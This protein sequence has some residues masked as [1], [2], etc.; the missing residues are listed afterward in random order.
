[1]ASTMFKYSPPIFKILFAILYGKIQSITNFAESGLKNE[2]AIKLLS[3]DMGLKLKIVPD[4]WKWI[5][6]WMFGPYWVQK[7]W[8]HQNRWN[9]KCA[10]PKFP[11]HL[12]YTTTLHQFFFQICNSLKVVWSFLESRHRNLSEK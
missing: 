10:W 8:F 11:R 4:S 6:F 2:K 1:M 7:Y 9:W 12:S 5:R 3:V